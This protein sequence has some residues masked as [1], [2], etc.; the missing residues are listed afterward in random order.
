MRGSTLSVP[1]SLLCAAGA[2]AVFAIPAADALAQ[3]SSRAQRRIERAV[4]EAERG[5][6]RFE[7][8]RSLQIYERSLFEVGGFATMTYINLDDD[9]SNNRTL[10][11]PEVT[12]FGR[13]V[14]DGAHTFFVRGKFQYQSFSEGDSFDGDGD[15]WNEPFL[16]R[17]W[18]EFDLNRAQ[19]GSGGP[20]TGVNFNLRGGRQFV[21][22]GAGLSLSEVLL[23]ARPTV[24]FQPADMGEFSIE[25]LAG[26]TPSD[27]SITDFDASRDDFDSDT[28]RG[29]FG[30]LLR[31]TTRS[32]DQFWGYLLYM[33]D[34]NSGDNPRIDIGV[35]DV[36]FDY[37]AFYLG[38]GTDGSFTPQLRYL[39]E[40]V[41]QF[42]KSQS[43]PLRGPQE[44]EDISA[45]A[46]RGQL[47]YYFRDEHRT[48]IYAET[49]FGSGDRDRLVTTDTVGG[50]RPGSTDRAFNS[51]GFS[52]TGLAF[53]P[54][55]SNIVVVR[56]GGMTT[57]FPGSGVLG[58]LQVG[59]DLNFSAKI[60]EDAPIEEPTSDD[61]YLGF[62]PDLLLNWR[63]TSDLSFTAR[64]GV[65]FP[66]AA[67]EENDVRQFIYLGLTL[68]F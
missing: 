3:D 36:D 8:D 43:D 60:L 22:W 1:R 64:Y 7:V 12:V 55:I 53:A 25:G 54:A 9:R 35:D 6:P 58:G 66:G 30:G 21:D 49:F 26:V 28:E 23:A 50:N 52:Y 38:I 5:T 56:V 33:P 47:S 46:A 63:L 14:I 24:T 45:F 40:V 62:E 44:E 42:G 57:P 31:Y 67:I 32:D 48:N 29:F 65:F 20:T 17:Y 18:Y 11:Q 51:L 27:E 13:A 61:R 19:A 34:F 2:A 15:G 4:R 59:L 10:W 39:G 16:D 41:Y 37:E 68:S